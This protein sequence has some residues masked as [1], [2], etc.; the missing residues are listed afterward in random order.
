MDK[1]EQL[2]GNQGTAVAISEG[3]ALTN[4]H[5][6]EGK[7]LL[8]LS[9]GDDAFQATVWAADTQHDRCIL[10]SKRPLQPIVGGRR[11]ASLEIGETVYTVGNPAGLSSTIAEGIISGIREDNGVT[12]VQT[13]API[14]P[15]SSG[16]ALVDSRGNLIGITEFLIRD[17]QNLN[18]AIALEEFWPTDVSDLAAPVA[19]AIGE[20]PPT[21]SSTPSAA[22]NSDSPSLSGER[23]IYYFQGVEGQPGQ[24][25]EGSTTWA[26]ITKDDRPAI[27]ATLKI[28]ERNV[29]V[30]VTIY[31]N[32]DSALPAS[33]RSKYNSSARFPTARSSVSRRSF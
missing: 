17:A 15:G 7:K 19:P 8:I 28:P 4:C 11:S 25:S 3:L 5:V 10:E 13:T 32:Y 12:F 26:E 27:Q 18:F 21:S 22:P 31:K 14:S 29:T 1:L 24:A 9:H 16:G 20:V 23:A 30:T 2:E 33:H 6:I